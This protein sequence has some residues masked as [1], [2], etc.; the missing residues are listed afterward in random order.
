[1]AQD[2]ILKNGVLTDLAFLFHVIVILP[3]ISFMFL[4]IALIRL[5]LLVTLAGIAVIWLA[6]IPYPVRW[7][8]QRRLA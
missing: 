7:Y 8:W 4:A 2:S 5:P 6:L 3:A 1:M